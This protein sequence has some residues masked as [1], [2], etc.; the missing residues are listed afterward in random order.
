MISP[1]TTFVLGLVAA[2]SVAG[3]QIHDITV[4]S[5]NG[6]TTYTPN[7]IFANP[8]D[9]VVFHFEQK[10]HT[11]TQSSFADPCGLK[12]GGFDSGFMPVG[13]NIT[14]NFPTFTIPVNDTE[15]IWV[16]C[17]QGEGTPNS[18][19]GLGMVFAVNCG[20]DGSANSFTAF[21][22]AALAEGAALR[23]AAS[24]SAALASATE[25]PTATTSDAW[26]TAAYGGVSI[27]AEPE[28][29]VVTESITVGSSAWQ[30]IYSSYIGSPEP[31]P[32]AI[33]GA[34]HTVVVGGSNGQLTYSPSNISAEP[35]DVVVFQFQQKNH[36]ATQSSF[37]DPCR[38]L[39]NATTNE[40][41]GLD[42]GFM[43]VEANA[44]EFPTWSVTVNDTAP[45]WFYCKQHA[46]DGS[47]HCGTGMVF[48]INAV[49]NSTRNFTAFQ[50]LAVQL[51][52]TNASGA[53]VPSPS[54]PANSGVA[55]LGMNMVLSVGSLFAVFALIL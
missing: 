50:S 25:A 48:A 9:Q 38:I 12:A 4:G 49:A 52:G 2:S 33:A 55:T 46:P 6:S 21:Q 24:S 27:P 11:A 42:S 36:T 41:I 26:T 10:N 32:V 31:T 47:S 17:R 39:T 51:N 40:V 13:P 44:T 37:A 22:Q 54:S 35:R 45:L 7:A 15:P 14:D 30:T 3:Q 34:V 53:A 28:P 16:Y 19:C 23:A 5:A 29:S 1:I 8:G 20:A 18:H 43:P